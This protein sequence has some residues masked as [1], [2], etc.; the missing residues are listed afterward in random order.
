MDKFVGRRGTLPL[1]AA[2]LMA[3]LLPSMA[4]GDADPP[5]L[6]PGTG[7]L[8]DQSGTTSSGGGATS[9]TS[10]M[11]NIFAPPAYVDYKRTGTE[12]GVTV[13][14]YPYTSAADDAPARSTSP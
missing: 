5:V 2:V 4:R 14:R 10:T 12:R 8:L 9:S 6:L 11:T 13:D 7:I 3:I 1:F